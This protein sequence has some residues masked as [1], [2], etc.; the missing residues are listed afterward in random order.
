MQNCLNGLRSVRIVAD[1]EKE[2]KIKQAAK[3][4]LLIMSF[5]TLSFSQHNEPFRNFVFL[6]CINRKVKK[7]FY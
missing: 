2:S 5:T 7:H 6:L 3:E 1:Q 4:A